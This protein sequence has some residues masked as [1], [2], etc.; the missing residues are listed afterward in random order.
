MIRR[1][2]VCD[3]PGMRLWPLLLVVLVACEDSG[4]HRDAAPQTRDAG[5]VDARPDLDSRRL[6]HVE[7]GARRADA[8]GTRARPFSRVTDAY[9]TA[10]S[11]D[12]VLLMPGD[13]AAPSDPPEGVSLLGAGPDH[14]RI[15]GPVVIGRAGVLVGGFTVVEGGV[16]VTAPAT[17]REIRVV[18]A[19]GTASFTIEAA[20]ELNGCEVRGGEGAGVHATADLVVDDLGVV[21]PGG[22][23]VL[24]E[25][26][27]HLVERVDVRRARGAGVRVVD[28]AATIRQ[29]RVTATE[30]DPGEATGSG[31][32]VVGSE[33]TLEAALVRG[34]DRGVRISMASDATLED[35]LVDGAHSGVTIS[36]GSHATVRGVRVSHARG[37]GFSVVD[38]SARID[39]LLV[40]EAVTH[41][42][43]VSRSTVEASAVTIED[44]Q[45]RGLAILGAHGSFEQLVVRRAG[46]VGVQ[47]TD[48]TGDVTI[49]G[50]VIEACRTTGIAVLGDAQGATTIRDVEIRGTLRGE[51]GLAEGVHVFDSGAGLEGVR[52]IENEGAGMLVERSSVAVRGAVLTGNGGPGLVVIEAPLSAVI[53]DC[54]ATGNGG[55]GLLFISTGGEVTDC[56]VS[57]S[58]PRLA[59]GAGDGVAIG[60]NSR[61]TVRGGRLHG[62]EGDGLSVSLFSEARMSGARLDGNGRFGA[63]VAC[64]G[65][66]LEEPSENVYVGNE[67]G[68][69]NECP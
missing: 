36:N 49:D 5:R 43:L 40:R 16:T 13:Y 39:G 28:A 20:A 24:L 25:G 65:S 47:I 27:E 3:A 69:R 6:W 7:P 30:Y 64:D 32:G 14:V 35:V 31:I 61:V 52:A 60:V 46:N 37:A 23:G 29:V 33:V 10:D 1:G 56:D 51:G 48:A 34:G 57:A 54:V 45:S 42:V 18:D 2:R 50:G 44:I 11:G 19:P 9:A 38:A 4:V 62:N 58:T 8:D 66:S 17:L 41:G 15:S 21:G 68:D 26:G 67:E 63:Y 53:D 59:E 55:A 22:I 12:I